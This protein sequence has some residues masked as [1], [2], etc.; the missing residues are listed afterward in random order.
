MKEL[1]T[2]L[3]T[4]DNVDHAG[5]SLLLLQLKDIHS[6]KM[7]GFSAS[8]N[9]N[10]STAIRFPMD[11]KVVSKDL[12]STT[13][14][15][16]PKPLKLPIHIPPKTVLAKTNTLLVE[17]KLN[18]TAPLLLNLHPNLWLLLLRDQHPSPL[19]LTLILSKVT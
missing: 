4:K 5:L 16:T 13:M 10:S 2:L 14:K 15:L 8:L 3:R 18:H 9:N 17:S 7:D 1:S 6:S 11:A 12:L 19:R